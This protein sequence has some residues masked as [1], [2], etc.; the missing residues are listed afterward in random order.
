MLGI[1]LHAF[2]VI[3]DINKRNTQVDFKMV[4]LEYWK[5]EY[6]SITV[7]ILAFGTML[8]VASEFIDLN[9][10]EISDPKQPL[11]EKLMHFQISRFIKLSSV[12]AGYF[13]DSILYGFFGVTEIKLK[14]KFSDLTNQP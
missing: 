9:H 13:A 8:F 5:T 11:S 10:V 1:V 3:R 4:F 14:K 12:I 2:K 7:S 6:L